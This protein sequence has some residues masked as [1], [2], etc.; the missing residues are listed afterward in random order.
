MYLLFVVVY[1]TRTSLS[2]ALISIR[3][4]LSHSVVFF[5]DLALLQYFVLFG[6]QIP[7][8]SKMRL[9]QLAGFQ[10]SRDKINAVAQKALPRKYMDQ[11]PNITP[12]ELLQGVF[13][14]D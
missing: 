3:V 8:L 4:A 10:E 14:H 7:E 9:E 5:N 11:H 6:L 13:A 12:T 2:F 1:C